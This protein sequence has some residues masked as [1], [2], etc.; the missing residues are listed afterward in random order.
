MGTLVLR[1]VC[2]ALVAGLTL[3]ASS[4]RAQDPGD[5]YAI[6]VTATRTAQPLSTVPIAVSAITGAQL[7][8]AGILNATDL[9]QVA[10]NLSIDRTAGLQIT[11]RG[12][13]SNDPSEK[14]DPSAAFLI[15]GIY[16]ARPQEADISFMDVDRVEVLRGPQGTQFGKNTTAGVVNVIT[17]RPE[18]G[19]FAAGADGGYGHYNAGNIDGFVNIPL[20]QTTALRLAVGFDQQDSATKPSP[21][22]DFSL[23]PFRRNIAL[24]T[25]LSQQLG[26]SGEALLRFSW[27]R[28][29]GTRMDDVP[30]SHFYSES[31]EGSPVLDAHGNAIWA[32]ISSNVTRLL[33][34]DLVSLPIP[35]GQYGFGAA[36]HT[37]P[38]VDD[39][40]AAIEGELHYD[41]GPVTAVYNGSWRHFAAH[42]NAEVDLYSYASGYPIPGLGAPNPGCP[43]LEFCAFP[44]AS[45]G[46]YQQTSNE[47]RLTTPK[48]RP[49]WLTVGAY[50]FREQSTIG[51][52]V[53]DSPQFIIGPGNT[54]YGFAN[55]TVSSSV[56]GYGEAGWHITPHLRLTAAL[57]ETHDNKA[58]TGNNL[59]L[60]SLR[61]PIAVPY[62]AEPND[63]HLA[64]SRATWRV[65]L[66]ADVAGGLAY[67]SM[68]TGY[69]QGGFGDGCS[70]GTTTLVTSNGGRCNAALGDP[71][72]VYYRP[73]MLTAYEL[74][75]RGQIARGLG[76]DVNA[77]IYDYRDMQLAS[78]EVIDAL[79]QLVVTNAGKARI[80]G[81]ETAA[82]I[83][84]ARGV[85]LRLGVDLLDAHYGQFCPGGTVTGNSTDSCAPGTANYAGRKLD[86]SPPQTLFANYTWTVPLAGGSALVASVG[87]RMKG[88][89]AITS[90]GAMPVQFFVPAHTTSNLSLTYTADKGRLY[91]SAYV[92]NLENFIELEGANPDSVIPGEPRT[93]G[94]RSGLRF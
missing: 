46:E 37:T 22:D 64:T 53:I 80:R 81:L 35:T 63:A 9:G 84:P 45:D 10:P 51:Y 49:I 87:T 50:A 92:M 18:F 2:K 93:Y 39:S 23:N 47:L 61:E 83:T 89:Y 60:T 78:I 5:Q 82:R 28:Q 33:T 48:S 72:A 90:Y 24:R 41:F 19:K 38:W 29:T 20:G 4:A 94:L 11:I 1:A 54:L 25:S 75:Y 8:A 57:R 71:Q 27:G 62:N 6:W 59:R 79:P 74:G 16:L 52:Y 91:L 56:A 69:K 73:E 85:L 3:C 31:P 13:T 65:G 12:V 7:Q 67:G 55:H 15:D 70:T 26:A 40:S 88:A 34:R 14:G 76:I 17:N 58:R 66:D 43:A 42:E 30:T 32:P 86:R 77:F 68:A 44:T 36:G 21:L